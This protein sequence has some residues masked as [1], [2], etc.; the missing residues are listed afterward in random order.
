MGAVGQ[1]PGPVLFGGALSVRKNGSERAE[2]IA[3]RFRGA[4]P[5]GPALKGATARRAV[6]YWA[7]DQKSRRFD[8]PVGIPLSRPV[9]DAFTKAFLTVDGDANVLFCRYR[10][11]TPATCGV[12]IDV[13]LIVFVA[14]S[15]VDHADV[16]LEPGAKMS[17]TLP[18]FE[19]DD[20]AS[21]L[22]DDPTVIASLTRAGEKL[23]AFAFELPAAIAYV[24][25]AAMEL[26]TAV[27]SD[28]D[29]PPP[30]LMFAT[31]GLM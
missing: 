15:L 6:G 11:A 9:V 1:E 28:G 27:S 8:V 7:E 12:A 22:V 17:T 18:K 10:A 31:A 20:R 4:R 16:M 5:F 24:T 21:V 30:R 2:T 29:T 26:R 13:P 19:N 3:D 23:L 14:V 25:P